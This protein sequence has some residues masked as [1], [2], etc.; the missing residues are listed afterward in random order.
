MDHF[1]NAAGRSGST[2]RQFLAAGGLGVGSVALA[3]MLNEEKLLAAPARPELEPQTFDLLPKQPRQ[4]PQ[5][6]AM[7]S[8]FMQGGPSHID[9]FDPKPELDQRHMQNFAGG[10]KYD[11][12]AEASAKL[13]ASPWKFAKHGECG[14]ELSELLPYLA[15]VVDDICL[16]RSMHT[17][18][19]NHGQ[20]IN[21][22]NNGRIQPA[23]RRSEVG[24]LTDS[25]PRTAICQRSSCSPIRRVC[26]CSAWR[27]GTTAGCRR[28]IRGR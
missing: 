14:T 28:C 4:E 5:A 11:N 25:V 24:W 19:N 17:G 6:T 22:L 16:I 1:S 27:T 20:S 9:L 3:W 13:F 2:R 23:G 12:A 15:N 10:I 18:V 7:I 26:R 21:A 8:L